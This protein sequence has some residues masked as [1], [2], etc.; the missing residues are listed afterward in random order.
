MSYKQLYTYFDFIQGFYRR[1]KGPTEITWT[2][3]YSEIGRKVGLVLR[4]CETL[5]G[6]GKAVMMDSG[7][8]VARGIVEL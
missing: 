6:T 1:R 5:Y 2:K 7:F 3:K 8:C 4:M